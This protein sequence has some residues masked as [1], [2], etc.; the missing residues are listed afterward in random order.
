MGITRAQFV[1]N[2][3]DSLTWLET[4]AASTYAS[5]LPPWAQTGPYGWPHPYMNEMLFDFG[6]LGAETVLGPLI[7]PLQGVVVQIA[8]WL[9]D[10]RSW[11]TSR[12]GECESVDEYADA[13][14]EWALLTEWPHPIWEE[15]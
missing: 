3:D 12:S 10:L 13:I 6:K 9:V 8:E 11:L 4:P 1:T 5:A 14:E 7:N 2:L 15:G